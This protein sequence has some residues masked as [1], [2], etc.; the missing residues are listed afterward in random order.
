MVEIEI[1]PFELA[2]EEIKKEFPGDYALQQIHMARK[3]LSREAEEKGM[4]F[5]EYIKSEVRR[6]KKEKEGG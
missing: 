2:F 1:T 3:I 5:I 6:I 4:G